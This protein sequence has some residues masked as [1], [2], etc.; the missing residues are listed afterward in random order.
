[1]FFARKA[2]GI[3]K[4]RSRLQIKVFLKKSISLCLFFAG[5]NPYSPPHYLYVHVLRKTQNLL[6][7]VQKRTGK[8][9][10]EN[11]MAVRSLLPFQEALTPGQFKGFF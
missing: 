9:P 8:D 7:F 4:N 1:M 5:G 6:N 11:P 2:V 3:A 10:F